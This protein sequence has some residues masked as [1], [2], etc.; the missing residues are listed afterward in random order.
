MERAGLEPATPSL[1]SLPALVLYTKVPALQGIQ[2]RDYR[3]Q[4][5]PNR[6]GG[7]QLWG[8]RGVTRL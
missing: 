2:N 5:A 4:L 6:L 1:Q 7:I 8:R 3:L